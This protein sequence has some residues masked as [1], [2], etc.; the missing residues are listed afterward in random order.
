MKFISWNVNGIRA[1]WNHGLSDFIERED[2][3]IY[4]FQETKVTGFKYRSLHEFFHKC[5]KPIITLT[6]EQIEEILGEKL[7]ANAQRKYFWR[8]NGLN[9]ISQCWID[10]GYAI[11]NLHLEGKKRVVFIL[12]QKRTA[13]VVMPDTLK[14]G[15]VPENAKYELENYFKYIIRKYGL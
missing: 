2:A 9:T 1:T 8:H 14:Y 13:S 10:N 7:G 15:R 5:E 3:D 4:A 11:K 12:T 6:F